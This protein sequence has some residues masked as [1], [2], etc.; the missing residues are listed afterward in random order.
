MEQGPYQVPEM[1]LPKIIRHR[2]VV[3][4]AV[5]CRAS[6]VTLRDYRE[7]KVLGNPALEKLAEPPPSVENEVRGTV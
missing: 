5:E 4:V 2:R 1:V 3:D 6:R 7:H